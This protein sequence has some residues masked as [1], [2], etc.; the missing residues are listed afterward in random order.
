MLLLWEFLKLLIAG[1]AFWQSTTV[2]LVC[3]DSLT[4]ASLTGLWARKDNEL[5]G[6]AIWPSTAVLV[7]LY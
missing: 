1:S 5:E 7:Q 3:F 6:A 2:C 4:S